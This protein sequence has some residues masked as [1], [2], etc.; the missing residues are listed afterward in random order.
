MR[1]G[2]KA[3]ALRCQPA[4]RPPGP[5]ARCVL[6]GTACRVA[7]PRSRWCGHGRAPSGPR[8]GKQ[9]SCDLRNLRVSARYDEARR[10]AQDHDK[11]SNNYYNR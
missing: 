9:P 2:W 8:E 3:W 4:G 7:A 10:A 1:L 6:S 11:G 5:K